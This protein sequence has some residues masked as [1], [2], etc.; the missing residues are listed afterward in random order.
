M[1]VEL[2]SLLP[3]KQSSE[4]FFLDMFL[5]LSPLCFVVS[6]CYCLN[7]FPLIHEGLQNGDALILSLCLRLPAGVS[8]RGDAATRLPFGHPV[9]WFTQGRDL[10]SFTQFLRYVDS[11]SVLKG[12]QL[13]FS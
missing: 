11:L 2:V 1:F 7:A 5:S 4:F 8:S 12:D 9:L 13:V 6:S 3:R 10:F